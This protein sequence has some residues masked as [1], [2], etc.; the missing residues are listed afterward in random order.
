M[1]SL[2]LFYND[3][4]LEYGIKS[5][6]QWNPQREPHVICVGG[7][8]AG[9]TY[10]TL[11]ALARLSLHMP[12]AQLYF[13]DYKG[14]DSFSDLYGAPRFWRF[15]ECGKGLSAFYQRFQDRQSGADPS[16]NLILLYFD[17][18]ASYC[19][20]LSSLTASKKEAEEDKKK[21]ATLL[22]MGRSYHV[23]VWISQQ[24]ADAVY[25]SN[26]RENFGLVCL[27]GTTSRQSVEMLMDDFKD[28]IAPD[29]GRGRGYLLKNGTDFY[30]ITVPTITNMH[31]VYGCI[32]EAVTR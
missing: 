2:D 5:Y 10:A 28:R 20:N 6:V 13:C 31:K 17:E 4:Y 29:R 23:H 18:Y 14:D 25:F 11:L 27:L 19:N 8:G 22:M 15:N 30:P 3:I 9:K 26:A 12:D 32:K 7:T 21:L 24:R 16:R 1:E